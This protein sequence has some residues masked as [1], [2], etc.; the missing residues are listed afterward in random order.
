MNGFR[1]KAS[2]LRTHHGTRTTSL[3]LPAVASKPVVKL[4][5]E[6]TGR[7]RATVSEK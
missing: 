2:V 6:S 7:E 1:S 3:V 4:A 5:V